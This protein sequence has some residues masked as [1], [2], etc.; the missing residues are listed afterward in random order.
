M[1]NFFQLFEINDQ[2]WNLDGDRDLPDPQSDPRT[3]DGSVVR[4]DNGSVVRTDDGSVVCT[5]DGSVVRTD[6]GTVGGKVL[7]KFYSGQTIIWDSIR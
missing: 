7:G 2:S 1:S 6:N 3:D 5:D 4:T